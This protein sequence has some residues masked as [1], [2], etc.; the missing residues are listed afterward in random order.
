MNPLEQPGWVAQTKLQP[1]RL[2]PDLIPRPRL[3][4]TLIEA[5]RAH[6]LTL[7]SAPAGYGKTTLL[8]EGG[9]ALANEPAA[10]SAAP[11]KFQLAW[12]SLD[13]EDND[14]IGF[15]SALIAALQRL[16]PM[17]G[18]ATQT[19]LTGLAQPAV[20][21]RRVMGVLI[22]D[23]L[24]ALP[25]PFVLILDDLHTLTDPAVYQG[26]DY[27][28]ERLPPP[29]R[30][31]IG[32]RHDPPLALARLRARGELAELR[33]AELRFTL[34]ETTALLNER[35]RLSLSA[36]DLLTLHH[37]AE[38][39]AAGL[40]LFAGSLQHL[41][42]F[43]QRTTFITSLVRSQRYIFDL[44]AEEVLHQQPPPVQTF[45]LETAI[46]PELTPDLCRAVTGRLD[47]G[48]VLAD[49]YRRNLFLITVELSDNPPDQPGHRNPEAPL[50][51]SPTPVYR[52][53]DL[54][55]EFLRQQLAREM[56]DRL[57]ELHRRA[58]AAQ[59]VPGR[60][61]RHYLA[62]GLWAEAAQLLEAVGEQLLGQNWSALLEGWIAALPASVR[63]SR[64][65]LLYFWGVC[66]RQRGDLAE[67]QARLTEARHGFEATNDEAGQGGTLMELA[68]VASG[69]H[70][71]ELQLPLIEAALA[72]PLPAHGRVQLLI[73][74]AWRLAY[75]GRWPEATPSVT[76]AIQ[77]ALASTTRS[78]MQ[79]LA[80]QMRAAFTLLPAQTDRLEPYCRVVLDRFGDEVSPLP[81]GAYSLL[82]YIHIL[83]GQAEAAAKAAQ[84]ALTLS[85]QLGGYVYI[86]NEIDITLTF[87]GWLRGD[88]QAVEQHLTAGWPRIEQT[89][90]ARPWMALYRYYLARTYWLQQRQA[91]LPPLLAQL[92]QWPD[93]Q[94]LPEARA[95]RLWLRALVELSEQRFPAAERALRQALA[96]QQQYPFLPVYGD[97]RTLLAE[98]YLHWNQPQAA[99]AEFAPVLAEC[100]Q[101]N[102]P[103]LILRQ[104]PPIRPLLRLAVEQP[105]HAEG[106][107]SLLQQL[108]L[109]VAPDAPR[110]F[111]LPDSDETLSAREV[112]VLRLLAAG[113]S[114][115][116]IAESLTLSI[117][118]V[119][120]HVANILAKLNVASR[121]QAAARARELGIS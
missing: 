15:L 109:A 111:P 84:R 48:A 52:Y 117:H 116:A 19:L 31:V 69:L 67:A 99:L 110:P 71:Y 60:A 29:M 95:A 50:S 90:A 41:S 79:P 22:N 98:L 106:A 16:N 57:P 33:L 103:G 1:P 73:L 64:P 77:L 65:R 35:L 105:R 88:F 47:A 108:D 13:A 62:A 92:D 2:R 85:R 5:V 6:P 30:V 55:A 28:L 14:P 112:E 38:G 23:I 49:L 11:Q 37:R 81:A 39:W 94:N 91:D 54:F 63:Q 3:R 34:A 9:L 4:Q 107:E 70:D 12:L 74:Q 96:I 27:L 61:I 76:E 104:G 59:P 82:G 53:H 43:T 72:Q 66:A 86:E 17:C 89:G 46:L 115:Q 93:E 56:P 8:A 113:A 100:A 87:S 58:A 7:V 119:K 44:L 102:R 68:N 36:A 101:W 83:R 121:T 42:P 80:L 97:T 118:T 114:N 21:I 20:E 40:R 10:F 75:Q 120:R 26:L 18:T 24:A 51:G 25:R 45:L 32:A 78:V